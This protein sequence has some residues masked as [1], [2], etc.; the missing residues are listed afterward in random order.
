MTRNFPIFDADMKL[1]DEF[2]VGILATAALAILILGYAYL[3]GSNIFSSKQRFYALYNKVDGLNVA[4]PIL[5]NGLNVGK[6]ESLDLVEGNSGRILAVVSINKDVKI[7]KD[8]KLKIISTDFLGA[9]AIQL[10]FGNSKDLA[11]SDDTL[12]AEN[13]IGLMESFTKQIE[14]IKEKTFKLLAGID[15]A[16]QQ[17]KP[18]FD[19]NNH[20]GLNGTMDDFQ[21]TIHNFRKTSDRLDGL[22]SQQ[23]DRLGEIF[24]NVESITQNLKNNNDA[25]TRA[26]ANIDKVSDDLAKSNLKQTIDN[27][28][29]AIAEINEVMTKIKNGQGSLGMLVNDDKLY[30]NLKNSS[31]DLDKLL[32]DLNKN[33][34][35]YVH[36]SVLGKKDKSETQK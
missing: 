4:N 15:S 19:K 27:A 26:L 17:L 35:K 12:L 36:F 3:R 2:K 6:V 30:N 7:P 28:S 10:V 5:V 13:E 11:E 31:D 24:K 32:I 22:V 23:T 25:I 1:S 34:G 33:P 9:K 16:L 21:T 20:N 18:M 8:S 14:P 29:K